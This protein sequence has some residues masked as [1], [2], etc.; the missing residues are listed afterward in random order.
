M[1]TKT[2]PYTL[3]LISE[4]RALT[5]N[6]PTW[7]DARYKLIQRLGIH[8]DNIKKLH[9]RYCFWEGGSGGQVTGTVVAQ[10]SS[11]PDAFDTE[12]ETSKAAT[13][14]EVMDLCKVDGKIWESKG[15]S[16]RRGTKGY[17]WNARF[18]KREGAEMGDTAL[19]AFIKAAAEH[20]P[21][22]W[23][24]EKVEPDGEDCLY[25]LNLQDI[26]IGK[27]ATHTETGAADWDI[28]I[29][30]K[31]YRGAVVELINQAPSERIEEVVVIVGSDMLQIDNDKSETSKGTFVDSDSRLAK[32]FDVAAKMLTDTIEELASRFKVRVVVVCGNHD[33]IT[34][35]FLGRYV[36][37]WFR[38]HPNVNV[39]AEPCSRKYVPYGRTLVAFDHG[40]ETP[41]KDLPLVIM[42][43]NQEVISQFKWVEAMVGHLH[44]EGSEDMKGVVVRVAPALCSPDKWHARKG[45]IGSIR[46]SQGLLYQR[47]NGLEAIFYSRALD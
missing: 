46:R 47:D 41:L 19:D 21:L 25:V 12:V 2:T 33:T 3:E 4:L 35:H 8:P 17:A 11:V 39:D 28:K 20:S 32:I 16:V 24:A 42:R 13:L 23:S 6:C 5:A 22:K 7:M 9:N 44:R 10:S 29:A 1:A 36:E 38:V 14:E 30:E 31:A 27:L 45:F 34:S 15:F 43:E 18:V 40:D 26:H 37:A